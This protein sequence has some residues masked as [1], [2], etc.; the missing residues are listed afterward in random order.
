MQYNR[1]HYESPLGRILLTSREERLTGLWFEGGRCPDEAGCG[2]WEETECPV[3]EDTKRWLDLYFCGVAP[4][5][6]PPLQLD[7]TPFQR[8]VLELL[9]QIPYGQVTTYGELATVIAQQRGRKRMS[10]QAVG[11]A[12]GA[13]PISIIIPC[14]RVIGANGNLTGYGGGLDRKEKLLTLERVDVEPRFLPRVRIAR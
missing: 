1:N 5:F 10:A 11:G 9:L 7:G 3:S 4:D 6:T 8:T 12:V 14:H 13:N 2:A